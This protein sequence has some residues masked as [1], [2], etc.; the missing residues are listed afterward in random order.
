MPVTMSQ[1]YTA[2]VITDSISPEGH[3][4][5]SVKVVYPHAVHKDML[6]HRAHNR[7]VESFRAQP[8]EKLIDHLRN[9]GAFMP[10]GFYSRVKGMQ[11]GN[12]EVVE[13]MVA[14]EHWQ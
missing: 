8:P 14:R 5:T 10:D 9:G 11:Q 4:I 1:M 12:S 2:T 7:N 13:A 6:R 3:R